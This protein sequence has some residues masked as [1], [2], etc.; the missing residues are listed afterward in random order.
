MRWMRRDRSENIEDRRGEYVGGG[1]GSS[2]ASVS[3]L[4][5]GGFLLLLV[6]SVVFGQNFFVLLD[7]GGSA[8]VN[9]RPTD[10]GAARP[11]S[12]K[13]EELVDFISFVLDDVQQTWNR[14][15]PKLGQPYR[16]AKLV[17][18]TDATRSGCG[19]AQS[20]MGPFY[21]PL[22]QKVYIDLGFYNELRQRFGAPGDFAQAYVIA[23]EI[24]HHVQ[25]LLGIS[26]R[27]NEAQHRNPEQAGSLSVRLELQADCLAGVWA[28]ATDQRDL[29]EGGDIEEGMG[30][31]A[32]VGD[33]RIQ[34]QTTGR[35]SPEKWTHGSSDQR[36]TWFKRGLEAGDAQACDTFTTTV[37][38]VE[39]G[40][41]SV[42]MQKYS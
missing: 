8:P 40:R 36:V 15:L 37:S 29:L 20:A 13:E 2:L 27:I 12:P 7:D 41:V 28:H 42:G 11:A 32:A 17:L 10:Q 35:V 21:C 31:A 16:D 24:G 3:R 5:I 25:H 26:D 6:L 33:D 9:V 14:E 22:D 38:E 39:T 19:F 34:R 30:A 23:H 1:I 4:G 18:F